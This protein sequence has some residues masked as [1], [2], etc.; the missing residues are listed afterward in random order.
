MNRKERQFLAFLVFLVMSMAGFVVVTDPVSEPDI[1]ASTVTVT[2]VVDGDT[3]RI[4]NNGQKETVRLV[5]IDT[6]E[7]KAPGVPIQCFGPEA[8]AKTSELVAGKQVRLA[9]DESQGVYDRYQRVLAYVYF[10][11][12][13]VEISLNEYLVRQGYA[14]VYTKASSDKEE[15][16]LQAEIFAQQENLGLWSACAN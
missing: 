1:S 9:Y 3:I 12:D 10:K 15:E 4:L 11:A 2:E 13:G 16:L 6:P 5:G 14:K 7:T 8:S